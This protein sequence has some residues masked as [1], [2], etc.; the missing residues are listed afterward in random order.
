MLA[1]PVVF[2]GLLEGVLFLTG[3]FEPLPVLKQVRH[4]GASYWVSEPEYGPHTFSRDDAPMPHHVWMPVERKPGRLRVVMLGES[5]VAGFPSEEY[6]LGRLTRVLWDERHPDLPMDMATVAMVGASSHILRVFAR[7]AAQLA[8]DVVILYAGHNEVIGPYGPISNFAAAPPSTSWA[9]LSLTVRNTRTGRALGRAFEAVARTV[10]GRDPTPWRGLDEHADSR[11]AADD[12]ALDR[13]LAQT[14]DNFRAIIRTALAHGSKVL[15]CVPAVNLNDWPPLASVGGDDASVSARAAYA[16][17]QSLEAAGRLDEAWPL[18]RRACDLDLMRLRADSR[19][20]RLSRDIA[21]EFDPS[22]V[23]VVDADLWLHEE[24][25]RFPGDRAYFL[26]HVHLTFE[27]RVAVASLIVDGLG[28]LLGQPG[29][30]L[31]AEQWW[32]LQ[33]ARVQSAAKRA[34]YTEFDEAH[35]WDRIDSLLGLSVFQA[36]PDLAGRQTAARERAAAL[37]SAARE[38][39][40]MTRANEA[41]AT[42]ITLNPADGWVDQK[43]AEIYAH[44]GAYGAARDAASA[45][46]DKFPY[47]AQPHLAL[48]FE[49]LRADHIGAAV[50]HLD[51]L[52]RFQPAGALAPEIHAEAYQRANQPARALPHLER[53]VR[54]GPDNPASWI[55]LAFAQS[56][57]GLDRQARAT[58]RRALQRR[59]DDPALLVALARFLLEQD[60]SNAADRAEALALAQRAAGLAPDEPLY[61]ETLAVALMASGREE[62]ARLTIAPLL[63][64]ARAA[65]HYD[66]VN[67]FNKRLHAAR[68]PHR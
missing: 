51:D 42:A 66:I 45:A 68:P 62:E 16:Q 1:S 2:F 55:G 21:A 57:L 26:E 58:Y 60:R 25:P 38:R 18:Y 64:E 12:P 59:P 39:W 20:R 15:V 50:A 65:G 43:A 46:R 35:L 67:S 36:L 41:R 29:E 30:A 4:E 31:T 5:A 63:D 11:V 9:Q 52:A 56:Q 34:I 6:S 13:M 24:N 49:A 44:L 8:P 22:D 33:P 23:A 14:A 48:A 27:G 54:R 37:Q 53:I 17:A 61:R 19:V 10:A 40:T 28:R 32:D 47:L 3:A 7:E